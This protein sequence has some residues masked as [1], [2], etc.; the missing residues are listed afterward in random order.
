MSFT[1][2]Q[3][4]RLVQIGLVAKET[5][6]KYFSCSKCKQTLKF[7]QMAKVYCFCCCNGICKKCEKE[8]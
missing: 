7:S 1:P 5:D 2:E 3:I 6:L 4:G 8:E